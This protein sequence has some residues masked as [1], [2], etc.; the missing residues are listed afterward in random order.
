MRL[1]A[2]SIVV[3]S[4]AV[5]VAASAHHVGNSDASALGVPVLVISLFW[6]VVELLMGI[7]IEKKDSKIDD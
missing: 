5:M 6:L 2:L 3:F 1:I 7:N 4:G